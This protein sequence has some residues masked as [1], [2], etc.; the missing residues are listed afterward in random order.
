M[1]VVW[2]FPDMASFQGVEDVDFVEQATDTAVRLFEL[3]RAFG[4]QFLGKLCQADIGVR[5]PT[6]SLE[7]QKDRL[8]RH[9]Q[10]FN[11]AKSFKEIVG[12]PS[13]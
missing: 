3:V 11:F 10:C 1:R 2:V 7:R 5:F 6:M 8:P 13:G 9:F 12:H 4:K